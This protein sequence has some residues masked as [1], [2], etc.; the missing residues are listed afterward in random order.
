VQRWLDEEYPALV[1]RAK[2]EGALTYWGDEMGLRSD[3][4]A[5]RSYGVRGQTPV[6][7]GTGKRFSCSMISA[8]TN[9]VNHYRLFFTNNLIY[10]SIVTDTKFIETYEV[11]CQCFWPNVV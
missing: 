7:P 11:P 3:H 10:H 5:G 9:R 4:Q 1:K 2:A 8:V 6:I